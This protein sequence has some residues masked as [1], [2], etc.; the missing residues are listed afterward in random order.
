MSVSP[1]A[2]SLRALRHGF[3]RRAADLA[4]VD[5]LLREIGQR[6]QERMRYIRLSPA[7]ALDLGCGRGHGLAALRA[8]YPDAQIAGLDLSARMLRE[9]ARLDPQRGGG[10]VAR[11]LG[12][13]PVFDLLQADYERLPFAA[14][15]FDMLWSNLALHWHAEPHRIFPEWH[16]VTADGGLLMFSLFGPDTLRELRQALAGVDGRPHTLR[17][18]DMHDIGDMLVHGG[19]STPVMDMETLTVTY[20]RPDTLLRDVHL[21]GGF[22]AGDGALHGRQWLGQVHAALEAQRN[23]DGVI[24]L[25]FEIV[26]GHAW[27]L[28][29]AARQVADADGRV[30]I[31]IHSIRRAGPR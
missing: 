2:P 21:M 5:Y 1:V 14:G 4:E 20:E 16:R 24:P 25:T 7:R 28:A 29:P 8:Q 17:F 11:L 22:A 30:S 3:D 27:K 13:R 23:Q 19:W 12:R 6:M 9:A 15:T 10:W 26:Y 18:V 31:P